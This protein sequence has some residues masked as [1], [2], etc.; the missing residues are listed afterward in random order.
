MLMRTEYLDCVHRLIA[1]PTLNHTR[2]IT[3]TRES[4][5]DQLLTPIG[6]RCDN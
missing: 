5:A 3:R 4:N 6:A 2:M 1:A